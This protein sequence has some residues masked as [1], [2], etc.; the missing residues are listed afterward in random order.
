MK[1]P[2]PV[3]VSRNK[4]FFKIDLTLHR[5]SDSIKANN[6]KDGHAA[7]L[8]LHEIADEKDLED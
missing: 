4:K 1:R 5:A 6:L 3:S 7:K 8:N 2:V